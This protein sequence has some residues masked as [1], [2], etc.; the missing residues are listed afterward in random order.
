MLPQS[1]AF[2]L[3]HC[4]KFKIM[5]K[6]SQCDFIK[7][8]LWTKIG[9]YTPNY[10]LTD[11]SCNAKRFLTPNNVIKINFFSFNDTLTQFF[12]TVFNTVNSIKKLYTDNNKLKRSSF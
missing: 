1:Y 8:C 9:L 11:T 12:L 7:S 4:L 10:G 5:F 3:N 2:Y 6:Y